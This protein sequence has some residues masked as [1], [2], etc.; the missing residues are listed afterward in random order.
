MVSFSVLFHDKSASSSII[1]YGEEGREDVFFSKGHHNELTR[2][3]QLAKSVM[4]LKVGAG[5]I[6]TTCA[7]R[8]KARW[9][10]LQVFD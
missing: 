7:V 3:P 4:V 10:A 2:S 9:P 6:G 5:I 1:E 8:L